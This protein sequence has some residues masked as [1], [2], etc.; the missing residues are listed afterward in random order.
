MNT[1][2]IK[3]ENLSVSYDAAG[4]TTHALRGVDLEVHRGEWVALIGPNGSGK[5]TLLR[6]LL[7]DLPHQGQIAVN[8]PE[9]HKLYSVEQNPIAGTAGELTVFE[10]LWLIDGIQPTGRRNAKRKYGELLDRVDLAEKLNQTVSTL[11]GGQR[12]ILTILMATLSPHPIII[13]DEPTS[14]LD[15]ANEE[16]CLAIVN[17]LWS[18]GRTLIHVTHNHQHAEIATRI[19]TLDAGIVESDTRK[20]DA[21]HDMDAGHEH[22]S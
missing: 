11:S 12:Q 4:S 1:P 19:V 20:G 14:A 15:H 9:R 3:I 21:Q 8:T 10:N 16:R 7:G 13:L 17:E 6:C 22:D 2:L 5:S 18:T